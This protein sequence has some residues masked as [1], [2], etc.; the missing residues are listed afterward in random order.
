VADALDLPKSAVDVARGGTSRHK[1][2]KISGADERRI[3][4]VFGT[5]EP[6][7]F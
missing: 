6:G 1:A 7:L 4:E 2:L 5:P 3:A